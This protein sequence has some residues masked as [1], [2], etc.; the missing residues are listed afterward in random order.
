MIK[1]IILLLIFSLNT[2]AA[3]LNQD[4]NNDGLQGINDLPLANLD[5]NNTSDQDVILDTLIESGEIIQ[6]DALNL[7]IQALNA[8]MMSLASGLTWITEV[9]SDPTTPAEIIFSNNGRDVIKVSGTGIN[10]VRDNNSRSEQNILTGNG[11]VEVTMPEGSDSRLQGFALQNIAAVNAPSNSQTLWSGFRYGILAVA[12]EVYYY[13]IN[14]GS[15]KLDGVTYTGGDKFKIAIE[16]GVVN[17]Y[18]NTTI[19]RTVSNPTIVYP[20]GMGLVL[21][22]FNGGFEN[23]KIR[24]LP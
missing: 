19:I 15:A 21:R 18:K 23:M 14:G 4:L 3:P 10:N 12:G 20:I 22:S 6:S 16:N 8:K 9:S 11:Y 17:Y 2:I 13:E 24:D 5:V 1:I 7:K